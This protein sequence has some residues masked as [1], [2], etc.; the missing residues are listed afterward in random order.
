MS[1]RGHVGIITPDYPHQDASAR[2]HLPGLKVV[3]AGLR[4][5]AV[6]CGYAELSTEAR[7]YSS[8]A[9][10]VVPDKDGR[11]CLQPDGYRERFEPGRQR[12]I[13]AVVV[14]EHRADVLICPTR[15]ITTGVFQARHLITLTAPGWLGLPEQFWRDL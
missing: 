13:V 15:Y 6:G 14:N 3:P 2:L 11:F 5:G 1:P 4:V 7:V 8:G 9:N 10:L 12:L